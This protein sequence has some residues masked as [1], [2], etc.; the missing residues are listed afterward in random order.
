ML[1]RNEGEKDRQNLI[2]TFVPWTFP[3][4][5][6]SQ[7]D[8]TPNS[9]SPPCVQRQST[10]RSLW[11]L[12][13]I[14]VLHLKRLRVAPWRDGFQAPSQ[15]SDASIS[16]SQQI[17]GRRT[18]RIAGARFFRAKILPAIETN[19]VKALSGK[20]KH[21][22]KWNRGLPTDFALRFSHRSSS[23]G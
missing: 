3:W 15:P 17:P 20:F 21:K 18:V 12:L 4:T 13:S 1:E 11:G 6:T 22:R 14:L 23:N 5:C 2:T 19:S 8:L 9:A 10:T 7:G 16:S